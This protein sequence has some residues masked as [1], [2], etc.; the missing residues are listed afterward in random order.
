[1]V[2][3]RWCN[4]AKLVSQSCLVELETL[5]VN[6]R[7]FYSPREFSSVVL[8]GVY[9]PPEVNAAKAINQLADQVL[10]VENANP[11]SVVIVVGGPTRKDKTLDHCYTVYKRA[12]H[13]SARAPLGRSDHNTVILIPAYRQKLKT[14][15]PVKKTVKKRSPESTEVLCGCFECMD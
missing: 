4:D 15:K 1:M 13:A 11:D 8:M 6:C 9:I 14:V 5:I 10:A 3:Q 7:P 12:Y 2:N